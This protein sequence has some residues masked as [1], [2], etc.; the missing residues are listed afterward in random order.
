MWNQRQSGAHLLHTGTIGI[1]GAI[2]SAISLGSMWVQPTAGLLLQG[3]LVYDGTL[4][5]PRAA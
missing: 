2:F 3:G 4:D 5:A 1:C